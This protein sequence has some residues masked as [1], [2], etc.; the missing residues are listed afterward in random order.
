MALYMI[1][2]KFSQSALQ[3]LVAKP[4]DRR[5]AASKAVAACGGKLRDYFFTFGDKDMMLIIEVPGHEEA[6]AIA[7]TSTGAGMITDCETT[8]L[9]PSSEMIGAMKKAGKAAAVYRTP[10]S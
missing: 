3:G 2:A 6:M 9:I 10:K 5:K 7:M 1:R 8:L 4:E